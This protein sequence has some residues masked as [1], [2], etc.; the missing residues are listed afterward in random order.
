MSREG[1]KFLLNVA[2]RAIDEHRAR[3][4]AAPEGALKLDIVSGN[5]VVLHGTLWGG[6]TAGTMFVYSPIHYIEQELGALTTN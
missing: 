1:A 2:D 6:N 4:V 5:N 3:R